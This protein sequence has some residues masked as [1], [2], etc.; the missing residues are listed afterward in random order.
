MTYRVG[1]SGKF[2]TFER[3]YEVDAKKRAFKL[4]KRLQVFELLEDG[5][6]MKAIHS[7]LPDGATVEHHDL[8]VYV[9]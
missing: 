5:I 8:P 9:G 2:H 4:P 1:F 7:V 6:K 3:I